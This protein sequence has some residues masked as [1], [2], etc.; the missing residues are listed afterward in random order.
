MKRYLLT[1]LV[2]A[3]MLPSSLFAQVTMS[4]TTSGAQEA[5][6]TPLSPDQISGE[7]LKL[8]QEL[9]ILYAGRVRP[10]V[11]F[12]SDVVR[13]VT[14]KTK[15]DKEAPLRRCCTGSPCPSGPM[16]LR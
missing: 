3:A 1:A 11:S 2:A 5:A 12:A 10:F 14:G 13:E 9:P 15:W 4:D 8:L 6:T 16:T 7:T